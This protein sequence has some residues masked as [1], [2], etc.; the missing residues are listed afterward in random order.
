[1]QAF[2]ELCGVH[3]HMTAHADQRGQPITDA[4]ALPFPCMHVVAAMV[5]HPIHTIMARRIASYQE[6]VVR[7]T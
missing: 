5:Q 7:T 2:V 1:M 6:Q 4:T 3:G